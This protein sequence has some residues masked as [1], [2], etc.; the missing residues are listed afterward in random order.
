MCHPGL[1]PGDNVYLVCNS[2]CLNLFIHHVLY[3]VVE[4]IPLKRSDL[5]ERKTVFFFARWSPLGAK[6][7]NSSL[8]SWIWRRAESC[9]MLSFVLTQKGT[10]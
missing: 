4:Y 2:L 8:S 3:L 1:L 6:D 9:V 5:E 10:D 7:E